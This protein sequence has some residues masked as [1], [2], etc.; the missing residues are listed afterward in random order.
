MNFQ[1]EKQALETELANLEAKANTLLAQRKAEKLD[2][3]LNRVQATAAALDHDLKAESYVRFKE[4]E[5]YV[6]S[7]KDSI[8][9]S[10]SPATVVN[11]GKELHVRLSPDQKSLQTFGDLKAGQTLDINGRSFFITDFNFSFSGSTASLLP[12]NSKAVIAKP[13]SRLTPYSS[14]DVHWDSALKQITVPTRHSIK[15]GEIVTLNSKTYEPVYGLLC[16]PGKGLLSFELK[17][18][19]NGQS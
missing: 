12:C 1:E 17:E 14:I 4:A 15:V 3:L 5:S 16:P 7:L 13:G 6:Q 19:D 8:R 11:S 18:I 10:G 2:A 9:T